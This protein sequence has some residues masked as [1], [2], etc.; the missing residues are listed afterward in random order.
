MTRNDLKTFL[1]AEDGAVTVDWVVLSAAIMGLGI[2]SVAAVRTGTVALGSDLETSLTGASVASIMGFVYQGRFEGG[3]YTDYM[4]N[5]DNFTD[6]Q[7]M[8]G[9]ESALQ[10]LAWNDDPGTYDEYAE[11]LDYYAAMRNIA[12]AR[13]LEIPGDY[14]SIESLDSHY[15]SLENDFFAANPHLL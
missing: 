3:D 13:G 12:E 8:S 2:A 4:A 9:M 5:A 1:K 14:P 15:Q 6:E 10:S 11:S 7:L